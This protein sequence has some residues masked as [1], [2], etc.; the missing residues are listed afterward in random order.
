MAWRK[1]NEVEALKWL[2]ENRN[3]LEYAEQYLDGRCSAK[4]IFL[5]IRKGEAVG[6]ID[7]KKIRKE[8]LSEHDDAE[9]IQEHLTKDYDYA[10]IETL[11]I[12][13]SFQGKCL[14]QE[15]VTQLKEKVKIPILVYVTS[16]SFYFWHNQ[17][18]QCIGEDDYWLMYQKNIN[19]Q[20]AV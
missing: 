9:F 8:Q 10:Y 20:Q 5:L 17:G 15:L 2:A 18:F 7:I 4:D 14:G 11:N 19:L 1:V 13:S 12:R 16:D 6:F 3:E